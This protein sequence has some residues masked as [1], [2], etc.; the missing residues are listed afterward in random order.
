MKTITVRGVETEIPKG[1]HVVC[2]KSD[3][4]RLSDKRWS[5]A[6]NTF[7]DMPKGSKGHGI[8]SFMCVIRPEPSKIGWNIKSILSKSI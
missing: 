8:W 6:T 2:N 5:F 4:V 1:Y 3:T 7:I